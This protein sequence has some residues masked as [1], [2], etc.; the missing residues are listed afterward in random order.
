MAKKEKPKT[1]KVRLTLES[2][3]VKEYEL[4]RNLYERKPN[5]RPGA[6]YQNV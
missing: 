2:G 1:H 4:E 6:F 5:G 3:E